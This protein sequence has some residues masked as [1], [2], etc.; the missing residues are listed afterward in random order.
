MSQLCP[1]LCLQS[2]SPRLSIVPF[3]LPSQTLRSRSRILWLCI[4]HDLLSFCCNNYAMFLF[5]CVFNWYLREN[6]RFIVIV[7]FDFFFPY[8]YF[9][10]PVVIL[11]TSVK[12]MSVLGLWFQHNHFSLNGCPPYRQ[13]WTSLLA[14]TLLR[15]PA[16]KPRWTMTTSRFLIANL[17]LSFTYLTLVFN[18]LPPIHPACK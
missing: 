13:P 4:L 3:L 15:S 10:L 9:L 7:A 6:I 12:S 1:S 17:P 14:R 18:P 11:C 16:H 5:I 2:H 8:T